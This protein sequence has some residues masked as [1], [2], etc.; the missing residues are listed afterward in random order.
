MTPGIFRRMLAT[1]AVTVVSLT[2][3]SFQGLNSLPLPGA[4]GRGQGALM[5]HVELANV[6]TLESNS[7]VMIDDVVV[8]SVGKLSVSGRHAVVEVSLKPG[9]VVPANAV[10]TVGQT[11]LLGSMHLALDPPLGQPPAGQLKPGSTIPLSQSSTYPSTEQTLSSLSAVVN[12]GTLGQIGEIIRSVNAALSGREDEVRELLSRLDTFAG[13]LNDERDDIV[14][15]IDSLNRLS[16]TFAQQHEVISRA[17]TEIPPALDVL[18]RQRAQFT[19]ALEKLHAFSDTATELVNA[20][21]ADLVKNLQNLEPTLN[22]LAGVGSDLGDALAFAT[23]F[24]LPQDIIDRGVR[25]DYTNFFVVVDITYARL[26]RGAFL[27]TR[28]G[29]PNAP[30]VP[31]PGDPYYLNYTYDPMAAPLAPPPAVPPNADAG[32][33]AGGA[34]GPELGQTSPPADTGT[35]PPES[36]PPLD[37][38]GS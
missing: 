31:A 19:T 12:G 27:G 14:A 11:S 5:Y 25:G 36:F 32:P 23:H 26:R 28:W 13:T 17:I 1:V 34:P 8:G 35:P 6:G 16:T 22:A 21:Q 37:Q 9:I 18:N 38:G 7:P 20:T 2:G 29:Q 30:L 4:V 10:G 15:A 33:T 24:P 3:C